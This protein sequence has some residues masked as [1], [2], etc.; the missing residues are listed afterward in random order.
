MNLKNS[1]YNRFK[2]LVFGLICMVGLV[3][4]SCDD[5]NNGPTPHGPASFE[6]IIADYIDDTS[7]YFSADI[8]GDITS[9]INVGFCWSENSSPSLDDNVI[10][11]V[12]I[13]PGIFSFRLTGLQED[14]TYFVRA[15]YTI[16]GDEFY[17]EEKVFQT[18]KPVN[19]LD[20][21]T[22]GTVKIGDQIWL[23]ENL[24]TVVYNNGDSILSGRGIGNYS[25]YNEP[26]F[27]FYYDDDTTHLPEYGKLYTWYVATDPRG[28]CP[29]EFRVP[30]IMDF[31]E[32]ILH[33]DPLATSINALPSGV[34]ELSAIAGGMLKATGNLTDDTG[35]WEQ[36]N[37]GASNVTQMSLLPSGL[38]DPSGSFDGLGFNAALWSFTEENLTRGIM[39]YSHFLNAGFYT[40]NFSKKS[41]YAVR[42]MKEADQ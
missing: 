25:N 39:F 4:N 8:A 27:Y 32:L 9:V 37:N 42:C 7:V 21:N 17:S 22:Y 23:T 33:L 28:V 40:N 1:I 11:M 14:R 2:Y 41:G 26:R 15:F 20:E 13:I 24:R 34:N 19:A 6:W 38:R 36:P 30:D 31:N 29:P 5:N 18:T 35:L 16:D 10:Y 3:V 12:E